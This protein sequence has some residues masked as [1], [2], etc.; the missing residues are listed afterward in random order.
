M[1]TPDNKK[2]ILPNAAVTGGA[3]VNYS[4]NDTRRIDMV[5]GISYG[6]DI[7]KAKT[8]INRVLAADDRILKDP[9]P[10]VALS[11]LADSSL[12]FVV[13]PWC[14]TGDYWNVRFSMNEEI[15]EAFDREGISI[16]FPQ[17]D[18]HVYQEAVS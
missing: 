2:I 14:K 13:R 10:T 17:R 1:K 8:I 4:A 15:K 16:P 11:E 6:D 5:F 18:V 12:N 7:S 3:I 9:A